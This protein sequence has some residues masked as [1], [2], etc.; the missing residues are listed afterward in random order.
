MTETFRRLCESTRQQK[1]ILALLYLWLKVSWDMTRT[2]IMERRRRHRPIRFPITVHSLLSDARYGLRTL[3]KHP[4]YTAGA[5]VTLALGIGATTTVF[6]Q[7]NGILLRPLPYAE[8]DR[9][10]QLSETAPGISS[11]DLSYPDFFYWQQRTEVFDGMAAFD[12]ARFALAADGKT[13]L[14][15]GA[16]VS[17]SIF[18]TLGVTPILGR[19]FL[20]GEDRPDAD[21]V[22]VVSHGF[23]TEFQASDPGV[24]G[25]S[26]LLSGRS[27]TV[28]G[29][30]PPNFMFPEL[31]RLWVPITL[32]PTLA[33]P[34]EYGWDAVA[35]LKDEVS[36]HQAAVEASAIARQLA[37]ANPETKASLGAIVYPLRDADIND[38]TRLAYWVLLASVMFVLLIA[39]VNVA[40]LVIARGTSRR[41]ELALR[42]A[43]GASRAR[44]VAQLLTESGLLA[45]MG[46]VL[47]IFLGVWANKIIMLALP[48]GVPFWINF[49]IDR[50]VLGFVTLLTI[51]T[52]L[53]FGLLPA[54]ESSSSVESPMLHSTGRGMS[55]SVLRRRT[56]SLLLISEIALSFVLLIAAAMMMR[57]FLNLRSASPG[58]NPDRVLAVG[59]YAPAWSY[60]LEERAALH[61]QVLQEV[62]T[63]PGV[64]NVSAVLELPIAGGEN[65]IV[66]A[67]DGQT[68]DLNT[69]P[70]ANGNVVA[71]RYFAAM[72]I[73]LILGR[74]FAEGDRPASSQTTIVSESLAERYW[75]NENPIGRRLRLGVMGHRTPSFPQPVQWHTVI[76]VVGDVKQEDLAEQGRMG[77]YLP[78][79]QEGAPAMTVVLRTEGD[80]LDQVDV[81]RSRIWQVGS[82]IVIYNVLSMEQVLARSIWPAR[83][84]SEMLGCFA[85]V[86][87]VLAAVGI[88][89]VVS[90]TVARRTNEI[91]V[92]MAMGA[93]HFDVIRLVLGQTARTIVIGMGLGLVGAV[94]ITRVLASIVYEVNA[95]SPE[96]F[97]V[98]PLVL[99]SV[100]LVAGFLPARR[101]A[102]LDPSE[103]LRHE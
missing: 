29:V 79:A 10:V 74:D 58:F 95:F 83:M 47:G 97:A 61:E 60:S 14:V 82:G 21:L 18:S 93:R 19:V 2:G 17:A 84:F 46:A 34:N 27:H 89:G 42:R 24:V 40:N 50:T 15:E 91:G 64:S 30:T 52:T 76:G 98:V 77:I 94:L 70:V 45:L 41:R 20:P 57:G 25:T 39:C 86:A 8:P 73:P 68:P 23:W 63:I 49:D 69:L 31:A 100:G 53:M 80:P 92:R 66:F 11:M 36:L 6:S 85:F 90:F 28:V 16:I 88:Y 78:L 1:G 67:V 9:L 56:R 5:V 102:R 51:A 7:V 54:M 38:N 43:V 22:V 59:I 72:Q 55:S 71:P 62:G 65:E 13:E 81:V 44:I 32:D 87:L 75:P 3:R 96:V 101:A 4:G 12:D 35:R 26:L 99:V 48:A 37:R 33:D 103:T